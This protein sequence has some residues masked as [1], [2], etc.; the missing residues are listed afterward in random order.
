LGLRPPLA[1]GGHTFRLYW[2][3]EHDDSPIWEQCIHCFVSIP[4]WA[5]NEGMW[6]QFGLARWCPG[7]FAALPRGMDE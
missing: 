3:E 4:V 2:D 7:M 1:L 6:S 5:V